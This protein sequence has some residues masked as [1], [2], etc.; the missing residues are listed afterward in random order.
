MKFKVGDNVLVTAGKDKG[1]SG[2]IAK[3][4]QDQQKV[5]VKGLNLYKRHVKPREGV[6]G[7]IISLERPLPVSNVTLID[8]VTQKPTRIGYLV[9]DSGKKVRIAK[10][11]KTELDKP[12]KVAKTKKSSKA[13]TK[14][15][16]K[17]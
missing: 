6:E 1:K 17:K 7:G 12:A 14:S 11:S 15:E 3:V 16:K 5:M 13:T 8:P 9:L 10:N 2:E 4:Y